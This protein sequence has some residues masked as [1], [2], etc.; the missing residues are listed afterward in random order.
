MC[1]NANQS[2]EELSLQPYTSN[3]GMFCQ[4]DL[5]TCIAIGLL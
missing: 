1:D 3:Y 2:L 4:G 5:E